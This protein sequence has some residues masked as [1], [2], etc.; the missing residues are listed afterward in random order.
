MKDD[1]SM[2]HL[3]PILYGMINQKAEREDTRF[4]EDL[5]SKFILDSSTSSKL[6]FQ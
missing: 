4:V 2:D 3:K 6:F 5:Q 1:K